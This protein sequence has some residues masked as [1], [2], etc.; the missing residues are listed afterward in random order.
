MCA[1]AVD[2]P[3][4]FRARDYFSHR[5]LYRNV[6][7]RELGSLAVSRQNTDCQTESSSAEMSLRT[8]L[9]E[10]NARHLF[11]FRTMYSTDH[12]KLI[13]ELFTLASD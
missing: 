1:C 13:R 10:L 12:A 3:P 9:S 11:V 2:T 7:T 8:V 5:A 4:P 6:V